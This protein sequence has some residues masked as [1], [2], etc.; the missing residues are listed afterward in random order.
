MYTTDYILQTYAEFDLANHFGISVAV[1]QDG[2]ILDYGGVIEAQSEHS[3]K[4][5][6][7]YYLKATCVFK[8]R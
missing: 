8:V 2:E 3:V 6:G 5:Q 1:W 4:I 7:A